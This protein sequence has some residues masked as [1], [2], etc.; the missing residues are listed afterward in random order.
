[1]EYDIEVKPS[2]YPMLNLTQ[3]SYIRTHKQTTI[4]RAALTSKIGNL[5][6]TYEELYLT[7]LEKLED[8]NNKIIQ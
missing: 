2:K 8:F 5:K 4:H 1:M 3:V 6:D 7:V